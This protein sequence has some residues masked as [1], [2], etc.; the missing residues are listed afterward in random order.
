MPIFGLSH[1]SHVNL[2]LSSLHSCVAVRG[3]SRV[4]IRPALCLGLAG[5]KGPY[6]SVRRKSDPHV[7][8]IK[9]NE[10]RVEHD[11][12]KHLELT[13]TGPLLDATVAG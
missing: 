8:V 10:L 9:D 1:V 12:P 4:W 2:W 7:G 11:V 5:E 3:P 13:I 6:L